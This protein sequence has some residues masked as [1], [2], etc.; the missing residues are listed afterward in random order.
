MYY[1]PVEYTF[2]LLPETNTAKRESG[3]D[4]L[5]LGVG[6]IF[7]SK[8]TTQKEFIERA[9][10]EHNGF[11]DYSKSVYIMA[12][13]KMIIICRKHGKFMQSAD[14]HWRGDGCKKCSI[15][16]LRITQK[17]F[18]EE[19]TKKHNG[20]YDYSKSVYVNANKKIIIVCPKHGEF[21]QRAGSHYL[22]GHGCPKCR[23]GG[24]E[25]TQEE[26]IQRATKK[27]NG[28][29][30]YSKS[31]YTV[32][33]EKIV[34][35]CPK[36]GEFKQA[37]GSHLRGQGCP[38]C[39]GYISKKETLWLDSINVPE[40]FRQ[41]SIKINGKN[42]NTDATDIINKIVW[43]FYGDY[44]HGN[45]KI[46]DPNKINKA[47]N[48]TFGELNAKT[49]NREKILKDAGYKVISIWESDFKVMEKHRFDVQATGMYE[50]PILNAHHQRLSPK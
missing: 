9:T 49:M 27:H 42:F 10:K 17:E 20:F 16:A 37:S 19:A 40:E 3:R 7:M 14:R 30:D 46:Y 4:H 21:K 8:K 43:E 33:L 50:D 47:T 1:D 38:K 12:R 35:I 34:I 24:T 44:W 26:F 36:H 31:F 6:H 11:Y 28:F 45:L 32:A 2:N 41:K 39:V 22:L 15:D 48:S 13:E 18:I 25:V 23:I 5:C 29:Y